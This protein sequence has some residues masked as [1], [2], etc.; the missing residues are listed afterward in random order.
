[1]RWRQ[2]KERR[3]N[4]DGT[5]PINKIASYFPDYPDFDSQLASLDAINE[6][7]FWNN[8]RTLSESSRNFAII[9]GAKV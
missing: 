8:L 3:T 9:M 6:K 7:G 5:N 1:V 4:V 2:S